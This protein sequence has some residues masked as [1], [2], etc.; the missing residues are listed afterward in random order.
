MAKG[1][2][3]AD[4]DQGIVSSEPAARRVAEIMRL[5]PMVLLRYDPRV[6]ET[7]SAWLE[8]CGLDD[9]PHRIVL[10]HALRETFKL[11]SPAPEA[12]LQKQD[13]ESLRG[14]LQGL[15]IL[16]QQLGLGRYR[17][18]P[19]ELWNAFAAK[20]TGGTAVSFTVPEGLPW[21]TAGNSPKRSGPK[22]YRL[23]DLERNVTWWYRCDVADVTTYAIAQQTGYTERNVAQAVQRVRTLL[24]C[25]DAPFPIDTE[26]NSS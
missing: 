5:V 13:V 12:V 10:M 4:L 2:S 1:A 17:W 9:L 19:V 8:I 14:E 7:Y 16:T 11:W 3:Q 21:A 20:A 6:Q 26:R 24:A 18:L 25:P 23:E 22:G 15:H